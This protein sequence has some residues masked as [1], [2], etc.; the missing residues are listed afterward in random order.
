MVPTIRR[1]INPIFTMGRERVARQLRLVFGG[2]AAPF[3]ER[4]GWGFPFKINLETPVLFDAGR[5]QNG[6]L[7]PA[8][9]PVLLFILSRLKV[10][11]SGVCAMH[12]N[13]SLQIHST[14]ARAAAVAYPRS[15]FNSIGLLLFRQARPSKSVG[16]KPTTAGQMPTLH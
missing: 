5:G 13:Y 1:V 14:Y 11:T 16:K 10:Q 7:L 6:H 4:A 9:Q 8:G 2:L 15:S 3:F 12:I